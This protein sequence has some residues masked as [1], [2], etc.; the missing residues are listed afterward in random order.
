MPMILTSIPINV[1]LLKTIFCLFPLNISTQFSLRQFGG[2]NE[3]VNNTAFM[4]AVA[5]D[6]HQLYE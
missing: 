2:G 4:V 5:I 6:K 1:V 3:M